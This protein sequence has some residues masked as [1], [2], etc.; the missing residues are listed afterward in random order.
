MGKKIDTKAIRRS[1][2]NWEDLIDAV[3]LEA[4]TASEV[5]IDSELLMELIEHSYSA[6]YY[7]A[8]RDVWAERRQECLELG[9]DPGTPLGTLDDPY[10]YSKK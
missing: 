3:T 9:I 6:G 5:T 8:K 4:S 7:R 1:V 2:D 10:P